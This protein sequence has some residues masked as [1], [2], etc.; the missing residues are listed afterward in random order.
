MGGGGGGRLGWG[1]GVVSGIWLH[2]C[3][4]LTLCVLGLGLGAS[5]GRQA[6]RRRQDSGRGVRG[7][8]DGQPPGSL[9]RPGGLGAR[10]NGYP[11]RTGEMSPYSW[12]CPSTC[13]GLL[14]AARGPRVGLQRAS[15]S[16]AG[17]REGEGWLQGLGADSLPP[18]GRSGKPAFRR[19]RG[20]H[21]RAKGA[22]RWP[23]PAG[24]RRAGE[25]ALGAPSRPKRFQARRCR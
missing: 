8:Q 5:R 19:R 18:S 17:L 9:A 2:T 3:S 15:A 21:G 12:L 13:I 25:L 4:C 20:G 7:C 6:E 23:G 24:G 14:G 10:G 11:G 1:R 16:R 22:G